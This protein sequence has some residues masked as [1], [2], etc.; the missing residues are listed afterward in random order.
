MSAIALRKAM[1]SICALL[2]C[3]VSLG[4]C[5]EGDSTCALPG[6]AAMAGA[7]QTVD[8]GATV[9]LDGSASTG[10]STFQWTQ[11]PAATVDLTNADAA[12]ATFTAP[13]QASASTLEFQ[14]T[15]RNNAGNTSTD[16]VIIN[17][18]AR[19]F[20]TGLNTPNPDDMANLP[21]A[22]KP[23]AN[24]N[25]PATMD[26]TGLLPP[27]GDQGQQ[28]SCTAWAAGYAGATYA[29]RKVTD[30]DTALAAN[31]A[32]P[33]YLYDKL[34][35]T[36]GFECG[37]GTDIR[38]ALDILVRTGAPTAELVPY[39]EACLVAP[40]PETDAARFRIGSYKVLQNNTAAIKA[41]VADGKIVVFG[42]TLYTDFFE[43]GTGVYQGNGV[44]LMQG[45]QHAAHAMAIVGYDDSLGAYRIMNSWGTSWGDNGFL[46][47][48]YDTFAA[49]YL[50]ALSITPGNSPGPHDPNGGGGGG[51]CQAGFEPAQNNPSICCPTGYPYAGNDGY[52]YADAPEDV[53]GECEDGYTPAL[54]NPSICC[55]DAFPY[56]GGDG[57]CY[58]TP[59]DDGNNPCSPGYQPAQNYPNVCCPRGYPYYGGD[60]LCYAENPNNDCEPGF[61]PSQ[62][63]PDICCPAGYPFFGYDG[64]CYQYPP[65]NG[66]CGD[67]YSPSLNEPSVCCP[68]AYPY[69]WSDGLCH[70]DNPNTN[71]TCNAGFAP[72]QN[73][74]AT[75]CPDAYPYDGFDGFCYATDPFGG[76][77]CN[78][79]YSPAVNN[80]S[81]CCPNGYP[82]D[83]FDGF[84]YIEDQS[85][86]N[87]CPAG[88]VPAYNEP[89]VC[90]P[91]YYPYWG[92]DGFCYSFPPFRLS[93]PD[94]QGDGTKAPIQIQDRAE[95]QTDES[96]RHGVVR[97]GE[98]L[99]T[100]SSFKIRA[101]QRIDDAD[102]PDVVQLILHTVLPEPIDVTHI[103]ITDDE[104]N[105]VIQDYHVPFGNG[106]VYFARNDG[107]QW[108][109]GDYTV[110][111][112]GFNGMGASTL[113]EGS[114][115]VPALE[116]A[117]APNT[118]GR[119]GA[120]A[121]QRPPAPPA[122]IIADNG[123]SAAVL[124]R[125][126]EAAT[127][128]ATD[129]KN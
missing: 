7:D 32:S 83:G 29:A 56:D 12:V 110:R 44:P 112:I 70:A 55:P 49:T 79:G 78:P 3:A 39:A 51:G 114:V 73:N 13:S 66:T 117:P 97:A 86:T 14:L 71:G 90:C 50:T 42:C 72:A 100:S 2:M 59:Q 33:M 19:Q 60:G 115:T 127:E 6:M 47:M 58:E 8:G 35:R 98:S 80:P 34:L 48:D 37:S 69:Y 28:S 20:L 67:G 64:F 18:N 75:C 1:W 76:N 93:N 108:L 30:F 9:Q 57:Y 54:N 81:Q 25:L 22:L 96:R 107:H 116:V 77:T 95:S 26:N 102:G 101:Q 126:A 82:Y 43:P 124:L 88:F 38:V 113:Y 128:T 122:S 84:C 10:G 103:S 74:P 94:P 125:H 52:C 62:N 24:Q 92:Y 40:A 129:K 89:T 45:Q 106:Y 91:F 4:V 36:H 21:Q 118:A 120:P 119:S 15:I 105:E 11:I 104:G 99:R 23:T 31:Q 109:P 87:N 46:W 53:G 63:E 61:A 41:E 68:D 17:V 65:D 85:S 27:I 121:I 5:C 123:K 16:N 111:F